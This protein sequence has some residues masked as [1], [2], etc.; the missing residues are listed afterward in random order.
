MSNKKNFLISFFILGLTSIISQ[1]VV[2][3]EIMNNFYGLVLGFWLIWVSLGSTFL[4]KFFNRIAALKI[5]IFCHLIVPFCFL[6]EILLLRYSLLSLGSVGQTSDLLSSTL[7]IFFTIAPLSIILGLQFNVANRVLINL[8]NSESK[9]FKRI[10]FWLKNLFFPTKKSLPSLVSKAYLFETYGLILGSLVYFSIL[11]YLNSFTVFFIL[12]AIN[13]LLAIFLY[14]LNRFRLIIFIILIL[15]LGPSGFF[16]FSNDINKLTTGWRF[17]AQQ[18]IRVDNLKYGTITVTKSNQ[19][20]NFYDNGVLISTNSQDSTLEPIIHFPLLY[21]TDPKKILLIGGGYNGA[22][23]ETLKYPIESVFYVELNPQLYSAVS[24][25]LSSPVAA[26]FINPKTSLVF[27]DAYH[28]IKNNDQKFDVIVVNLPGPSTVLINRYYTSDFSQL[29]KER[30]NSGGLMAINLPVL[31]NYYSLPLDNLAASVYK[32]I[33]QNYKSVL[34]L[35]EK[36]ILFL[37]SDSQMNYN[38]W[39]L[40]KRYDQYHLKNKLVTK[41]YID[42]RLTNDQVKKVL[43][44][45]TKNNTAATNSNL[46]PVGYWYN[47]LFWLSSQWPAFNKLLSTFSRI[48]IWPLCLAVIII[49]FAGFYLL[50]I[51]IKRQERIL[52]LLTII[53]EFSLM[54][55]EMVFIFL[56]QITYGYIYHQLSLILAT[57]FLG[58]ALGI[59]FTNLT[60]SKGWAKYSYLIRVFFFIFLYFLFLALLMIYQILLFNNLLIFCGLGLAT[61]FFVGLKFP[62]LNKFYLSKKSDPNKKITAIYAADLFGA[63]LGAIITTSILL[64]VLGFI[65]TMIFL[66]LINFLAF[67]ALFF[68]R[69]YFEQE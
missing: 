10:I 39:P 50:D 12:A 46:Q 4:A 61:S 57:I 35:P 48:N 21:H 44:Q 34:V 17:F 19:Q 6:A 41:D 5:L 45:F 32:A 3:R 53:P 65:N 28:F 18:L 22:I 43:N 49:F 27:D 67:A 8:P 63:G 7:I 1:L 14:T 54:S 37:A 38:P 9:G 68:I 59:W 60:V 62:L 29:V 23:L 13:G 16:I 47:N 31:S 52:P 51:L 58:L 64:P 25:Y 42:Y 11:V 40:I 15:I 26:S 69:Q 56:F 24:Q 36:D 66:A 33:G 20:Y 2:I 55:A 30:L